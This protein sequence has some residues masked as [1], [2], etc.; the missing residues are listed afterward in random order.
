[1]IRPSA[2]PGDA[3]SHTPPKPLSHP[4]AQDGSCNDRPP[5]SPG[6]I[7]PSFHLPRENGEILSLE[8]FSG[9]NLV[10][11][12]YPRANTPG[13]TKEAISFTELLPEF[14]L[15]NTSVVGVSADPLKAQVKFQIKHGLKTPLLS[16]ETLD[17]LRAYG[18]WGQKSMYG[19]TFEGVIRRTVL[20]GPDQRIRH[21]WPKVKVDGHAAEVLTVIQNI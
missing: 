15:A 8:D 20:I 1:M 2:N 14:D 9:R 13:C 18:A 17:M 16:D 21:I 10:L 11:Y 4:T 12:F 3:L 6:D 5:L 19:K 7:A